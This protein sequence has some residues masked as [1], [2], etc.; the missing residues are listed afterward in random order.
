MYSKDTNITIPTTT[1]RIGYID[2]I[3]GVSII[4]VVW[5]H[6]HIPPFWLTPFLVN[7]IFFFISGIFFNREE[8]N[9]KK[10]IVN[11]INR[12]IIPFFFFYLASYPFRIAVHLWD[13]RTLCTFDW[14][15][16]F[17]VFL[18]KAN[19]DY[20]FI[21]VPLWFL[22]CL[23]FINIFYFMMRKFPDKIIIIISILTIAFKSFFYSIP[24]PFMINVAIY[25]LG[26]FALGN[27]FGK[28]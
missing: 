15:C 1:N 22:P 20:L 10:L 27:I 23:F 17:D 13:H 4:C 18:W 11:N 21:N 25:W 26:I 12:I 5:V 6:S 19:P 3:K 16:I 7:F 28:K 24:S 2:L 9:F 14:F 8:N